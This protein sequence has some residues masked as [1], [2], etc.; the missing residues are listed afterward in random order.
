MA[1]TVVV[2]VQANTSVATANIAETTIAVDNL[3]KAN[4]KLNNETEKVA[5]GFENVTKNGGAIAILDQLTGGLASRVR[6]SYE[7]TKLF[8]FSLKGMRTAFIATGI[9]AFVVALGLVAAYWDEITD[10]ITGASK[11]LEKQ[12]KTYDDINSKLSNEIKLLKQQLSL[13]EKVGKNTDDIKKTLKEKLQDQLALNKARL[14][15]LKTSYA[16]KVARQEELEEIYK[17]TYSLEQQNKIREDFNEKNKETIEEINKLEGEFY[18][19]QSS[20]VDLDQKRVD[21]IN[22]ATEARQKEKE[23]AEKLAEVT[24]AALEEIR[25]GQVNTQKELRA[26]E[27]KQVELQYKDLLDKAKKY[28]GKNS[29]QA[30]ELTISRDEKLLALGKKYADEDATAQKTIDDAEIERQ[31]RLEEFTTITTEQK[32]EQELLAIQEQ[33]LALR[34]EFATDKDALFDIEFAY[35]ERLSELKARYVAEDEENTKNTNAK[36]IADKKALA[37]A[38]LVITNAKLGAATSAFNLLAASDSK[39]KKLQAT[40][41]I[42]Q[43]AVGIASNIINTN[44]ANARLAAEAG[45]ASPALII[46]NNIR[47]ITGIASSVAATAKGLSQLNAGGSVGGVD[48]PTTGTIQAPSFNIVGQGAGSQ[49]ASALGDQQQTPIQA[50]VVS[51]DVT[52]AQSLENGIIQGAT[53]GG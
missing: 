41:L 22:A 29:I 19:I 47:M 44:A 33:N 13:W 53:L 1:T 46:A 49:I 38:E 30:Q 36:K 12:K 16:E 4:K 32:R 52:S 18:D 8:N 34:E 14:I 31:N 51:Q 39:N 9:G 42:G 5:S 11:E 7:A 21:K 26:E 50:Y 20:L 28:Y 3:T 24:A 6:D 25:A 40:A 35:L 2:N 48:T 23:E 43:N 37:D 15:E 27:L 45:I 17:K 10:Y